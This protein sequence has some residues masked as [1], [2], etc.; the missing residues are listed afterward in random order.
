MVRKD[1]V[2]ELIS[3]IETSIRTENWYAALAIALMLP[4]ICASCDPD[5]SHVKK[6]V[7]KRYKAW[8]KKYFE[9]SD[10]VVIDPELCYVLRCKMLHEASSRPN[11]PIIVELDIGPDGKVEIAIDYVHFS[12]DDLVYLHGNFVDNKLQLSVA[13]FCRSMMSIVAAWLVE[14]RSIPS[15]QRE[16]DEMLKIDKSTHILRGIVRID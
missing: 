6:N 16:L 5:L 4:D 1:T 10:S 2:T 12:T 14:A 7:G 11:D 13:V 3:S 9:A 8:C 15:V